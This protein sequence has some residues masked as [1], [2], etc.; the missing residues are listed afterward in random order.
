VIVRGPG[1]QMPQS[2]YQPAHKPCKAGAP[3]QPSPR[4]AYLDLSHRRLPTMANDDL[5]PEPLPADP[6]PLFIQWYEHACANAQRPNPNAMVLATSDA[7][8][9]PSARVVLCK[10]VQ[11]DPGYLVFFTNR[12]SRKGR[13][14]EHRHRAAVV[15][16]WD[17][18]HRQV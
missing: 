8:G 18:L 7:Q 14:L 4:A 6:L 15:F 2:F 5:L 12:E 13:E 16:H 10:Q 11:V 1:R 9:N 17:A 3:R